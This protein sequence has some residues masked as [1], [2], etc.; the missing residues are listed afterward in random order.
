MI[1]HQVEQLADLLER[2]VS[3]VVVTHKYTN[4]RID[5]STHRQLLQRYWDRH[6]PDL[7]LNH[8]RYYTATLTSG[9]VQDQLL[10]TVNRELGIL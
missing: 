2:A 7:D 4:R 6:W 9:E 1:D 5:V 10:A 3:N 8:P